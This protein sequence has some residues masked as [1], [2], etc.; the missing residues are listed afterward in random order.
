MQNFDEQLAEI[1][2][3]IEAK[4]IDPTDNSKV[5]IDGIINPEDYLKAKYKILWILKEPRC[6]YGGWDM[7]LALKGLKEDRRP[8]WRYAFNKI[9]YTSF[10][11]LNNFEEWGNMD[12]IKDNPEMKDI[13]KSIAYINLKK[14]PN[15]SDSYT[16]NNDHIRNA[17]E[18]DKDIIMAQINLFNPDII[19]GGNTLKF[20]LND[21][22]ISA[23]QMINYNTISYLATKDRLFINAKHPTYYKIPE[24][25]Y[26]DDIITT[27]KR[28]AIEF[29]K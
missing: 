28:W 16:S 15:I 13:L 5:I 25:N 11:I 8:G 26:S 3:M 22:G 7:R 1:D 9:I 19:I 18:R 29:D 2:S 24:A 12:Y 17:Y 27:S 14:L 6:D 20:I 23:G 21:L 10:G 4:I